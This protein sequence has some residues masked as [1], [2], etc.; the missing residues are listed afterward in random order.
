MIS[1]PATS[2]L[3][4]SSGSR[5]DQASTEPFSS[6]ALPSA[7]CR[8]DDRD[9]GQREPDLVERLEQEEV[10]VGADGHGDVLALEVFDVVDVRSSRHREGGPVRLAV[11]VDRLDRRAVRAREQRRRA[12]RRTDVDRTREQG[13]VRLVRAGRL[14]PGD[15]DF[16]VGG[17]FEPA[18]VLD[19]QAERVVGREVDVERGR[20]PAAFTERRTGLSG[21]GCCAFAGNAAGEGEGRGGRDRRQERRGDSSS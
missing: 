16:A 19:D 4:E 15:R 1:V 18:L 10:R 20:A 8:F 5:P 21:F 2:T 12:G 13:F 9:V 6:A 7:C 17:L 14:R 11:D 3:V